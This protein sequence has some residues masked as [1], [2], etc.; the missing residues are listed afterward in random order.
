MHTSPVSTPRVSVVVPIYNVERYLLECLESLAHQTLSDLEV[1]MVDDGSTDSSASIAAAFAAS[2]H[3][4]RLVQQPNGGLGNARNTGADHASGEYLAFVDSDDVVTQRAYEMLATSLDETGSDFAT[5]N[6]HR[7]TTTGTRQAGMVFTAFNAD[8]PRTHVSK[9]PALLNDRTAWNKLFRRTFWDKH[10]FRWPEGVLYEDIPVTLRAHVLAGKVDVVREPVYL[11]R[12]RS[13]DSASITQRRVEPRAVGDRVSA[14]DGVSRFMAERGEATL[15]DLYDRSVAAQDLR[16]FLQHLDEGDATYHSVF[17]DLAN[18]FF[19]RARPDVFDPLPAVQRLEWHLVRRRLLPELLDVVR[20]ENEREAALTPF[21]RR[22]RAIY[23][24]YPFRDDPALDIPS[25]VYRLRPDELPMPAVVEDVWWDADELHLSGYA[26]IANVPLPTEKAGRIRLTL[27][28]S[29]RRDSVVPL[30]LRRVRRPDLAAATPDESTNHDW[31]GWEAS[32]PA[33]ALTHRGRFRSGSWRLRVEVRAGGLTRRRWVSATAPGRASRPAALTASGARLTPTTP[34]GHF[35]VQV[36]TQH[37]LVDRVRLDGDVLELAGVL[38]GAGFDPEHASLRLARDDGRASIEVPVSTDAGDSGDGTRLVARLDLSR[39]RGSTDPGPSEDLGDGTVWD[40]TLA[41]D[42]TGA[43]L[44]LVAAAG[45]PEPS[46][47]HG[48]REVVVRLSRTGR[49]Q[50]VERSVRPQVQRVSWSA[51]A[52]VVL[53][54]RYDE[55]GA[56][57]SELVLRAED[58]DV[59]VAV[60]MERRDGEFAARLRPDAVPTPAGPVALSTGRWIAFAR[61]VAGSARQVRVSLD[62]AAVD[63]LPLRAGAGRSVSVLAVEERTLA[64]DVAGDL[65]PQDQARAGRQRLRREVFAGGL[66]RPLLDQ[67]LVDGYA[68]CRYGEDVAALVEELRVREPGLEIVWTTQDGLTPVPAGTRPVP[69]HGRDWYDALARSR[70]VLSTDLQDLDELRTRPDQRTLQAWHGIPADGAGLEDDHAVTRRGR[71]GADR[72]RREAARWDLVLSA[73]PRHTGLLHRAFGLEGPVAE[74]GLPRH[75]LLVSAAAAQS[76]DERVASTRA[77]LGIPAGRRVVLWAPSHRPR[78]EVAPDRYRLE[79]ATDPVQLAASLGDDHVLL[80]RPHPKVVDALPDALGPQL[81]DATWIPDARD[82]L[83]VADV[84]V[85]DRS[86]VMFDFALTGRPMVFLLPP[87]EAGADPA[88][89]AELPGRVVTDPRGLAE[90]VRE[91]GDQP[92]DVTAARDALLDAWVPHR[93]GGAAARAVDL[94][95]L[96]TRPLEG[97]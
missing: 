58:R 12:A 40:F 31:A 49:V 11:W 59:V 70:Y 72:I 6:F 15:K 24:D 90:A 9:H 47:A 32:V 29:G 61:P 68:D 16:Y 77:R 50:V 33:T 2:D 65:P 18:D 38:V 67:V 35:A 95:L 64:L 26:Y 91:S 5:G 52:G 51:E 55:E 3:R 30:T 41:P 14:V 57:A 34:A 48:G 94:L 85:T 93:D 92:A 89:T 84:L 43:R 71:H 37:V 63:Q 53:A 88:G 23:G 96:T 66:S 13:G 36:S 39:L 42:S 8:R 69:R 19:D 1:V 10:G 44:P 4:F 54:G 81:I 45:R 86:S 60:P 22:G 87:T 56:A 28:E 74:T 73:G 76:R 62:P 79:L 7:L 46:Q 75:D 21:V 17:L 20:F 78:Q 83:L 25:E 97:T 80:V 82:L 27:E